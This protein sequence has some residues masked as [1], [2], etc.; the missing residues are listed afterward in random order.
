MGRQGALASMVGRERPQGSRDDGGPSA[1]AAQQACSAAAA[2]DPRA[3]ASRIRGRRACGLWACGGWQRVP[4][5]GRR[6]SRAGTPCRPAPQQRGGG[7]SM[8]GGLDTGGGRALPGARPCL[9]GP[10][11]LPLPTDRGAVGQQA[12]LRPALPLAPRAVRQDSVGARPCA[13]QHPGNTLE[14]AA[15]RRGRPRLCNASKYANGGNAAEDRQALVKPAR[16]G[17]PPRRCTVVSPG[18]PPSKSPARTHRPCI[19]RE[20]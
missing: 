13:A 16:P 9:F 12:K 18:R 15:R 1:A 14:V 10:S 19:W 7:Q 3:T 20:E 8:D 2:R 6:R 11:G 17:K 4:S 5:S